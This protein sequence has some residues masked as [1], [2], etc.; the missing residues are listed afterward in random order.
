MNKKVLIPFTIASTVIVLLICFVLCLIFFLHNNHVIKINGNS[1]APALK[2]GVK[3]KYVKTDDIKRY[4]IVVYDDN[5]ELLVKRVYGLPKDIIEI[6]GGKIFINN[7]EIDHDDAYGE[8]NQYVYY[9]LNN[10]EFFVMGDNLNNS[11]DSR[12]LGPITKKQIKG[13]VK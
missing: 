6:K 3:K 1:M 13:V 2:D 11:L 5:N 7:K 10:D 12:Q 8:L 4:D 9:V